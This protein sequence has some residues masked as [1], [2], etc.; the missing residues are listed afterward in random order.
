[1]D[2]VDGAL[3]SIRVAIDAEGS[4]R[5][6]TVGTDPGH[7]FG[8]AAQRCAQTKR[9]T[10]ALDRDGKAVEGSVEINV[11]FRRE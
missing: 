2:G 5:S 6:V 7:G 1:M 10:P 8:R 9:W 4:V 3:V 11:R